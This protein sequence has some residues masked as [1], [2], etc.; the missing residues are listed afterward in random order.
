[1]FALVTH[2][3]FQIFSISIAV[4]K[5]ETKLNSCGFND[6]RFGPSPDTLAIS[7]DDLAHPRGF[8]PEYT[9]AVMSDK[10]LCI[11]CAQNC[12]DVHEISTGRRLQ[13]TQTP[14]QFR[15]MGI[16]RNGEWLAIA[17]GNGRLQ[18]YKLNDNLMYSVELGSGSASRF[19]NCLAFS[20]N[21]AY[22]SAA[23]S[24]NIIYTYG[25]SDA[26][27]TYLSRFLRRLDIGVG[28]E[29]QLGITCL[30]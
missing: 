17:T 15:T 10:V 28:R 3:D 7:S 5:F 20:P 12:V 14:E 25:L 13:N 26:G 16:S 1:L 21:S 22:V 24:E 8:R 29:P 4:V 2:T 30:A 11:A 27:A 9:F 23:T 19:I 6:G 18:L